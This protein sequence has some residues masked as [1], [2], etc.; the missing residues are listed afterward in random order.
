MRNRVLSLA[1]FA[2]LRAPVL[3]ADAVLQGRVVDAE[4]KQP[5]A[6]TVAVRTPDGKILSD[7]PSFRGGFRVEGEFRKS[8]PAETA[9]PSN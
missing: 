1:A 6:C 9:P 5:I 2:L 4:T 8:V 7:H 3:H